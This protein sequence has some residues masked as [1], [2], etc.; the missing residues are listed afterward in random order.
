MTEGY[1]TLLKA[2]LLFVSSR[3]TQVFLVRAGS[4][5]QGTPEL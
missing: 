2:S 5:D 4:P 3:E 1:G